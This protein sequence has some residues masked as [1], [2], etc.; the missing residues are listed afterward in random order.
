MLFSLFLI[1]EGFADHGLPI[2]LE[3]PFS[4]TSMSD[5]QMSNLTHRAVREMDENKNN[6]TVIP[7]CVFNCNLS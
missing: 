5:L 1:T 3:Y 7:L 2:F 6:K 4:M